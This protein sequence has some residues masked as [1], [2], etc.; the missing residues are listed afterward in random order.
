M[1]QHPTLP[2]KVKVQL[3]KLRLSNR[4]TVGLMRIQVLFC[5]PSFTL[6]AGAKTIAFSI[7][8]DN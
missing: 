3:G 6:P 4:C 8:D 2:T 7:Y 1:Q 5:N